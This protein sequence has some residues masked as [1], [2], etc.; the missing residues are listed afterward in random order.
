MLILIV[1]SHS[2]LA[3]ETVSTS[4]SV[5]ISTMLCESISEVDFSGTLESICFFYVRLS[6]MLP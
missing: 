1:S 5:D 3:G 4:P 2:E 6:D